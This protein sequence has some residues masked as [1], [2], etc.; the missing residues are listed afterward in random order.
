MSAMTRNTITSIIITAIISPMI[1]AI[2]LGFGS[3]VLSKSEDVTRLITVVEATQ[4]SFK[5]IANDVSDLKITIK[6]MS[7]KSMSDRLDDMI[8]YKNLDIK[9]QKF[10]Q[11][12]E[13][14]QK[15]IIEIKSENQ[16]IRKI[17]Y[18]RSK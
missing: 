2:L 1:L 11:S 18:R 8:M 13:A 6:E 3:M 10:G 7:A 4:K 9:V 14:M 15:A 12:Q 17:L 16:E 5:S